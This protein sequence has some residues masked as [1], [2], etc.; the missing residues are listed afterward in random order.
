M[1]MF[2]A[3]LFGQQTALYSTALLAFSPLFIMFGHQARYY[4]LTVFLG[5]AAAFM[6]WKHL[7]TRNWY[8]LLLYILSGIAI[9]N[10]LFA[11]LV[12]VG[13]CALWWVG[14]WIR[15]RDRN[16]LELISWLV[17]N[18]AVLVGTIPVLYQFSD[19]AARTPLDVD[20]TAGLGDLVK[21]SAYSIY[22][23]GLGETLS[24]LSPLAW[25]GAACLVMAAFTAV[26]RFHKKPDFWLPVLIFMT[27][28]L[29]SI[30]ATFQPLV[31]QTWQNLPIRAL[32]GLP[33]FSMWIGVGIAAMSPKTRRI[34]SIALLTVFAAATANYY[35]GR[36]YLRPIFSV[37]WRSLFAEIA[38]SADED[39]LV[40]CGEGDSACNYYSN[41]FGFG[42]ITYKSWPQLSAGE[43]SEVWWIQNNLGRALT[44]KDEE[45]QILD[46]LAN[47][48]GVHAI[49]GYGEQDASIR[50]LKTRY[51]GQD[52][53]QFR[54][55][56]H[57][58]HSP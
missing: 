52:D 53:Y 8:Y 17:A 40:V 22:V 16:L 3:S 41:L 12:V 19:V 33:F 35:L 27:I 28:V 45:A 20:T 14:D 29:S 32:Y 13:A 50:R 15:R 58:F 10:V 34:V 2:S 49:Q 39:A 44:S 1:F 18:L 47:K 26:W 30:L 5:L 43:N 56:V 42:G 4:S 54:V 21:R 6:M 31:S 7:N 38:H 11:G 24:P 36:Q 48:F 51:T 23:Y 46:Q 25:I 57:H 9:V 37:Q 55:L